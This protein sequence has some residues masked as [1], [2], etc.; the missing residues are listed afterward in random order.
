MPI[1]PNR[2]F[3]V[4]AYSFEFFPD[5]VV[6]VAGPTNQSSEE[7]FGID[8]QII[9]NAFEALLPPRLTDLIDVALAAY[10]A[11][12]MARRTPA[13]Y[14]KA[15]FGWAR[16][17]RLRVGVSDPALWQGSLHQSLVDTLAYFTE[18]EWEFDFYAKPASGWRGAAQATLFP[19]SIEEPIRAA[20]FSG[21][22]DSLAGLCR[23]IVERPFGTIVLFA[24][25]TN[26]RLGASQSRLLDE[27]EQR[28]DGRGPKLMR[29]VVP[30]GFKHRQRRA[31][32]KDEITQ[33]TRGFVYAAFGM[34]AAVLAGARSLAFYENGIGCIN[35]PYTRAQL[36]THL[37]R[38][39]HPLGMEKMAGLASAALGDPFHFSLPYFSLT[40][41]ELCT[42][43]ARVGVPDLVTKTVSC[44]GVPR[45]STKRHCGLCTSCVLR[46]QS[47]HAAELAAW[48]DENDY[49]ENVYSDLSH[50]ESQKLYPFRAMLHQVD[51]L[52]RALAEGT[53]FSGLA[54]AFPELCEISLGPGSGDAV[55]ASLETELVRLYSRYCAEWDAFPAR[56]GPL[57]RT[58][59]PRNGG[60]CA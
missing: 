10:I 38:A 23:E 34:A 57:Q 55:D 18:D 27:L 12:R 60:D 4:P 3:D 40:K 11:D 42:S 46:R 1:Q 41:G 50:V 22:L 45:V 54:R 24:G 59:T 7:H 56:Q 48:D 21:G 29:C 30:F 35:L 52:K 32:D 58:L 26:S 9:A 47:L 37:T 17:L 31:G 49:M 20:L 2:P 44:D 5:G 13:G 33:R 14:D 36:G 8:D 51:C 16:R 19:V 25:R 28:L 53:G 15:R 39:T 6:K 43:L